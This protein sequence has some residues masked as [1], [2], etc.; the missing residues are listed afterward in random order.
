MLKVFTKGAFFFFGWIGGRLADTAAGKLFDRGW[1]V[2][3][4]PLA[5]ARRDTVIETQP[6]YTPWTG[7]PLRI[8]QG[9]DDGFRLV[10]GRR[11]SR[12]LT[13]DRI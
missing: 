10:Y 6:A 13:P 4:P 3:F 9:H 7:Q 8:G 12:P 1:D 2:V 11:D 5:T